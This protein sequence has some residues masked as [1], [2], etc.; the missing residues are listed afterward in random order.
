MS[1]IETEQRKSRNLETAAT[2]IYLDYILVSMKS[3][4]L[5]K[6]LENLSGKVNGKTL[7]W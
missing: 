1:H 4:H 2:T 3:E 5:R 6:G 7:M